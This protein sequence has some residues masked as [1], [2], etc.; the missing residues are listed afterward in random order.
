M[1]AVPVT[2]TAMPAMA[3]SEVS[4]SATDAGAE[5]RTASAHASAAEVSAANMTA[6]HV[7]ATNVASAM[8]AV[9]AMSTDLGKARRRNGDRH[10]KR[11]RCGRGNEFVLQHLTT[12][13]RI[14]GDHRI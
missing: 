2:A 4:A 6:T 12:P 1:S 9:T 5:V 14:P 8:S 3:A 11:K 10:C 7:T 13:F